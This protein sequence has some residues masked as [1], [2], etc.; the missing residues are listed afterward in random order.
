LENQYAT[1]WWKFCVKFTDFSAV[2]RIVVE[3]ICGKLVMTDS[4]FIKGKGKK[5]RMPE[6]TASVPLYCSTQHSSCDFKI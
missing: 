1:G 6:V 4:E 2:F 3:Y 5:S